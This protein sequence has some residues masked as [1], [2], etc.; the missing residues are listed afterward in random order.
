MVALG[1]DISARSNTFFFGESYFG[2]L[3]IILVF[4]FLAYGLFRRFL[5]EHW[6]LAL[7][8]LF[9]AV[10]IGTLFGTTF[11][12]YARWASR[13][14][15][16]PMAYILFIAGLLTLINAKWVSRDHFTAGFLGA[17]LL[18]LGIFMKPI[19]APGAAVLLTGAGVAA[20][21]HGQWA[22]VA[23][24]CIGVLPAFSMTLHN[25]L[26]GHVFVLFSTNS[27]HPDVLV[28]PPSS[29][30]AALHE[31]T[32]LNFGG[33]HLT[34]LATN[35]VAWLT[36][37]SALAWHPYAPLVVALVA[38]HAV[39]LAIVIYVTVRGR[40]FDPWLRLIGASALAQHVVALFYTAATARYHFLTWFLT[41]LVVIVWFQRVG[42]E[43][44]KRQYPGFYSWLAAHPWRLRL[45]SGLERLQKVSA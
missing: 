45:A 13:G 29:Y 2:Y 1:C 28:M 12:Q 41:T 11:V 18:A 3:S 21:Y 39:A 6:A 8:L 38:L 42:I 34:R 23:G 4:P 5:P 33:D 25:W 40:T 30:I 16:D 7:I 37:P 43:R 9:I 15:A 44:V 22:R 27:D 35:M 10:P 17:L 14:F 19:V 31:L 24:L 32:Q 20:L 26:Y 36:G